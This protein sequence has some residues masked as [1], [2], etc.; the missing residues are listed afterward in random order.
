MRYDAKEELTWTQTLSDHV[1]HSFLDDEA[2]AATVKYSSRQITSD[3]KV[4]YMRLFIML[5]PHSEAEPVFAA[6]CSMVSRLSVCDVDA[7]SSY[8]FEFLGNIYL[9]KLA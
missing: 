7:P 2:L 3:G 5:D 1:H 6:R 9:K 8:S 4:G